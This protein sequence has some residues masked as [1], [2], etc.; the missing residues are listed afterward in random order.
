MKSDPPRRED[1]GRSPRRCK[2]SQNTH[3][4]GGLR[5]APNASVEESE[6]L[7]QR[8]YEIYKHVT[9]LPRPSREESAGSFQREY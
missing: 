2:H 4:D 1:D 7:D 3:G 9:L 6:A 8:R 5:S